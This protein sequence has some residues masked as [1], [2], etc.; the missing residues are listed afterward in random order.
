MGWSWMLRWESFCSIEMCQ[1]NTSYT[2][3]IQCYTNLH[4]VSCLLYLNKAEKMYKPRIF[5]I[6]Y[7]LE[8]LAHYLG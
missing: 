6:W 1:I 3:S 8:I 5:R 2:L 4:N 7:V